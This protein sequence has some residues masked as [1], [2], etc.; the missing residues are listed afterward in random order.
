MVSAVRRHCFCRRRTGYQP[1]SLSWP[2]TERAGFHSVE[3]ALGIVRPL[4]RLLLAHDDERR[5]TGSIHGCARPP[6]GSHAG[7]GHA[8]RHERK[9][10]RSA[11]T[12][13]LS[14]GRR[15]C[16]CRGDRDYLLPVA[17]SVPGAA[18]MSRLQR[19]GSAQAQLA[20]QVPS[21]A[22]QALPSDVFDLPARVA[23]SW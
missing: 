21:L 19:A 23:V 5:R 2:A 14:V 7:I 1:H 4:R 9:I 17:C 18:V 3:R 15:E 22:R 13:P 12:R 20:F 6:A 10:F 16:E 11:G 8:L